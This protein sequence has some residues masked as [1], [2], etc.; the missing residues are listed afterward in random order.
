MPFCGE[1]WQGGREFPAAREGDGITPKYD[2]KLGKFKLEL[3]DL[4]F[5][6][7]AEESATATRFWLFWGVVRGFAALHPRLLLWR[8][9]AA[10]CPAQ[11]LKRAIWVWSRATATRF[12]LFWG[13]GPWVRCASPTAM[14]MAPLR[15]K[16]SGSTFEARNLGLEPCHRYAVLAFFGGWSVGSLRFT[17]G[18]GGGAAP[19]QTVRLNPLKR[20]IWVGGGKDLARDVRGDWRNWSPAAWNLP[21]WSEIHW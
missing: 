10:N 14:V 12:W 4:R 15:G 1:T 20:A 5:A 19:R 9:S 2:I 11:P 18:Y 16:L 8:R 6:Q 17:H 7:D 13:G 3:G 21:R